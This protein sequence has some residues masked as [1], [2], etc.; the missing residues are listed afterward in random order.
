MISIN[1]TNQLTAAKSK[2]D[3]LDP[4]ETAASVRFYLSKKP[5][6]HLTRSSLLKL[7]LDCGDKIL[8]QV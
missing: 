5:T 7:S 2:I 1:R 8:I 3:L 4:T 6:V